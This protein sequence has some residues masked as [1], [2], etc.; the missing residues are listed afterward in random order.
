MPPVWDSRLPSTYSSRIDGQAVILVL[1]VGTGDGHT[2][3]AA[4]IE[5]IGIVSSLCVASR[6]VDGD[7][8]KSKVGGAIDREALNGCVLDVQTGDGG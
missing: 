6:V 4:N 5:S 8:C 1:D 3:A 7:A 2:R